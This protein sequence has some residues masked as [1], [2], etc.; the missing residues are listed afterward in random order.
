MAGGGACHRPSSCKIS[1]AASSPHSDNFVCSALSAGDAWL[2]DL[3]PVFVK[4]NSAPILYFRPTRAL[5]N[6]KP[7][8]V[9]EEDF[10][11]ILFDCYRANIAALS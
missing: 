10:H 4:F 3:I 11:P 6:G 5:A 7:I 1:L 2:Y 8:D 9:A